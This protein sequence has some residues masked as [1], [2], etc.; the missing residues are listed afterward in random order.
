MQTSGPDESE[1]ISAINVTPFV[2]VS[3]VLLVIFMITAPT[4]MKDAIGIQLPKASSSDKKSA[5]SIG[6]AITRQGQVLLNGQSL[7]IDTLKEEVRKSIATQP[8]LQ[9]LISADAESKHGDV[10][11]V[12]DAIKSAG[13]QKFALQIQKPE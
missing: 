11:K 8:D 13:L 2:D 1:P 7:S 6:I 10:V 12:I 4:L 9:A 3:L 5:Q